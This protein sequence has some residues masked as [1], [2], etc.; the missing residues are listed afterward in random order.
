MRVLIT[1]TIYQHN[2]LTANANVMDA[3]RWAENWENTTV[4][5]TLPD[6]EFVEW[7]ED[8]LPE[9]VI[10]IE[11]RRYMQDTKYQTRMCNG[12]WREE[13]LFEIG[14]TLDGSYID[15]VI[16]QNF[17]GQS[18]LFIF[19]SKFFDA[20][21][22][23]VRPFDFIRNIHDARVPGKGLGEHV[24]EHFESKYELFQMLTAD[25][26][27]ITAPH[28]AEDALDAARKWFQ[29]SE[30]S[31][32]EENL[33]TGLAPI[34][35]E[36]FEETYSEEPKY[37]HMAGS[38][39]PKKN[40][41]DVIEVCEKL[42][43]L[44]D[45]ETIITSMGEVEEEYEELEFVEA[46]SNCSY[47]MYK[48]NL[49]RGDIVI[50]GT[51]NETMGRTWFEQTASGQVLVA[52]DRPWLYDQIP[53]DYK[54]TVGNRSDL[55]RLA[56]WAVK[57]WESAV[58]ENQRMMEHVR[59]TR[60]PEIIGTRTYQDL[61][62][63]IDSRIDNYEFGWDEEVIE[64]TAPLL[65]EPFSLEEFSEKSQKFTDS[66]MPVTDIWTYPVTDLITALRKAGYEDVGHEEPKF[67]KTGRWT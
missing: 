23:S 20:N 18:E 5:M 9:N 8:D 14:E 64:S 58:A 67:E 26:N 6:R 46:F 47:E 10:P 53:E 31:D 45:I 55:T 4:Y 40:R 59:D 56:V 43:Q 22:A 3:L 15:S 11:S 61:T 36:E 19:L 39:Y 66:G 38:T 25:A 49:E 65:S 48:N 50:S 21:Y 63:K 34:D 7:E 1:P 28:D 44:F 35:L 27:W 29:Y 52:W 60:D 24:R 17:I 30:V 57:N 12:S 62:S 13:Q 33:L 42:Y 2:Y 37:V 41:D 16:D 51:S 32:V 54:L